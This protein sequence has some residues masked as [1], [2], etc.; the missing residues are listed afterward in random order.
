MGKEC[1]VKGRLQP[2]VRMCYRGF[3]EDRI[4]N[5]GYQASLIENCRLFATRLLVELSRTP[6]LSS[7]AIIF[8]QTRQV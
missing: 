1:S 3:D 4:T 8:L 6:L 7:D 5:G 2:V